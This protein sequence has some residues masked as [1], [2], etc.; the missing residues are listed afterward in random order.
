[1]VIGNIS[2]QIERTITDSFTLGLIETSVGKSIKHRVDIKD[3][4]PLLEFC[5]SYTEKE[6]FDFPKS[7]DLDH[8]TYNLWEKAQWCGKFELE[9]FL[10]LRG[11]RYES[12]FEALFLRI[13]SHFW[14]K[15]HEY[16]AGT[17]YESCFTNY[18]LN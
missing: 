3:V 6:N 14:L 5:S 13:D 18:L 12:S 15:L 4:I 16:S 9:N 10:Y 17:F 7:I 11:N 8:R 2:P 1:V